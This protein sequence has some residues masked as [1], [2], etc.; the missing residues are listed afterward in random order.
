MKNFKNYHIFFSLTIILNFIYN[1]HLLA[2]QNISLG[3]AINLALSNNYNLAIAQKNTDISSTNVTKGNAGLLPMVDFFTDYTF[4]FGPNYDKTANSTQRDYYFSTNS[5][6]NLGA[7]MNWQI[8]DGGKHKLM[9]NKLLQEKKV[10]ISAQNAEMLSIKYNVINSFYTVIKLYQE[11][12]LIQELTKFSE[13]RLKITNASFESGKLPKTDLLQ[14]TIDL[15]INKQ[16]G[17]LQNNEIFQAIKDFNLILGEIDKYTVETTS[18]FDPTND[19]TDNPETKIDNNSMLQ[20][21]KNMIEIEMINQEINNEFKTPT[22]GL[23]A[24]ISLTDFRSNQGSVLT[25]NSIEPLVGLNFSYPIYS[26]GE[27]KRLM[28]ISGLKVEK[29]RLQYESYKKSILSDLQSALHDINSVKEMK[30]LEN[31]NNAKARENLNISLMRLSM[32]ET[33]SLEVH[34]AEQYLA[35]S[36]TR[37]I[38]FE[39]AIKIAESKIRVLIN[40]L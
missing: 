23:G 19:M 28:A 24:G 38:N 33:T 6:L 5:R 3:E 15:N 8:Y 11:L 1:N 12:K 31:E 10:S 29:A 21:Y 9:Y 30:N 13:E 16:N 35:Q 20:Y 14:A 18:K 26:A 34:Q 25:N 27:N 7:E 40:E 22:L 4:Q 36:E 2:Q 37:L 32:G 17:L 39:Y